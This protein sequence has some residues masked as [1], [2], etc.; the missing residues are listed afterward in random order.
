MK[1]RHARFSL[2]L[3]ALLMSLGCAIAV[4]AQDVVPSGPVSNRGNQHSVGWDKAMKVK[5]PPLPP[6]FPKVGE[7]IQRV[8]LDNGLVVYLQEDH[9]LPLLNVHTLVR[10][11]TYYETPDELRYA[12]LMADQLR[13]GGTKNYPPDA[14]EQKL[15]FIAAILNVSME[16]EQCVVSLNVPEKDADEGLKIFADVLRNPAFDASRLELAKRQS[17]FSL[18]ASNDTPGPILQ[19]EFR[20]LMY[21]DAHPAGRYPT[22][23][24]VQKIQR[25]DL[26]RF[27]QKYFH[28]NEVMIGLSGDFHSA[29]MLAK[30]K[31]LFGDW[32]KAEVQL[33]PLPHVNPVDKP[34]VYYVQKDVNQSSFF[35]AHWGVNRDNP[36]RFAID[37]MNDILGGSSFSS[38]V[39]ERVRNDLGLAYDIGT[40]FTTSLRDINFFVA[41][42]ETKTESTVQAI[43][44]T[45]DVVRNM[46]S[47]T[48]SK[49]E[50][51]MAKEMV[52]Y[53][54]V[55]E[56]SEPSQALAGLMHLEFEH[57]PADYYEK[58]FAGYQAVT[59]DDIQRVAKKYLHP[60]QL[61]IFIVGDFAKLAKEAAAL[62]PV[63]EVQPFNFGQPPRGGAPVSGD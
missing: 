63:K 3:A 50:F 40:S 59:A 57:L 14:L 31:E 58:E 6:K 5:G 51:D 27:Y 2:G 4:S 61:T 24:Q 49:N 39:M 34:G 52:L 13:R 19:R 18:M 9:R 20:R 7:G 45:I 28:P 37:L 17:I 42:G 8:V 11:G 21:T 60:D 30:I 46:I 47:G 62:G 53:S 12:A 38:R 55:F 35:L 32:P 1:N 26:L 25:D 33:P 29:D 22:I 15:D 48:I 54:Q 36:D 23:A 44:A 43:Q 10:T 41:S 56:F 16:Q